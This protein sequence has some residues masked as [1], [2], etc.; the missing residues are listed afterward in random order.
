MLRMATTTEPAVVYVHE[1][2]LFERLLRTDNAASLLV[3]R[4]ALGIVMLPHGAQKVLGW[5]GGHGLSATLA[6]FTQAGIPPFLGVLAIL[7]ESLGA[8]MLITGTL[9]RIAAFGV[10]C[11]MVVAAVLVHL[12]NGF[13]MNWTGAQAGEGFEF[14]IL[15]VAL[16][17]VVMLKGA[18]AAS[19]DRAAWH[20]LESRRS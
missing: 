4:V 12:K 14:H 19:V 13:F 2:T 18:G 10:G 3:G 9:T 8:I 1:P 7:A 5:F 11:E 6:G 15:A 17:F 16:A 20:S